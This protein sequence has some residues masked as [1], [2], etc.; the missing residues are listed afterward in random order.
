MLQSAA[1]RTSPDDPEHASALYVTAFQV[2]ILSGSV[3]GGLVY[4]R[5]GAAAVLATTAV[6]FAVT[7]VGVLARGDM[8]H[9]EPTAPAV[10]QAPRLRQLLDANRGVS[11]APVDLG[12]AD[13][14]RS[15]ATLPMLSTSRLPMTQRTTG[16]KPPSRHNVGDAQFAS[17]W[18]YRPKRA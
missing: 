17:Q 3:A 4:E 12:F 15:E 1:I 2:G 6:L 18:V 13:L 14:Q 16:D 11:A 9:S 7:L 10:L 8:F 5:I